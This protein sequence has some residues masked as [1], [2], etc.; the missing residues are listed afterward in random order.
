MPRLM[1]ARRLEGLDG[2]R[3]IAALCV[4]AYHAAGFI[5]PGIAG[6]A[7]LAVD[8]FFLLSGFVMA[9]TYDARL[10]SG[11]A[12]AD[13][14]IARVRRLWPMMALGGVI[15]MPVA[16]LHYGADFGYVAVSGLLLVPVLFG[17][18]AF[19]LNIPC[20][21][22]F[23]EL[24]ANMFHGAVLR[25]VSVR[26][27]G[28][29]IAVFAVLMVLVAARF[30]AD[31]GSAPAHFWWALVRVGLPYC[32]GVLL[33]RLWGDRPPLAVPPWIAFAAMP[34]VFAAVSAWSAWTGRGSTWAL[35]IGLVAAL[36]PLLLMGG[37]AFRG[38]SVVARLGGAISF[39]LYAVHMPLMQLA[40]RLDIAVGWAV[41]ASLVLAL[42]LAGQ[43]R[44][45]LR[46]PAP[47][48]AA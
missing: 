32:S 25:R 47:T 40:E 26:A 11:L 19:P 14:M 1:A 15:G 3:G 42:L 16:W 43:L 24:V 8:F 10:V 5:R 37:M 30:G 44:L 48:P 36:W 29:L 38:S 6:N 33:W 34:I 45:P 17:T 2:L 28:G 20:W 46:A 35:D 18:A 7:Y 9:R 22:I 39:P 13:F 21:S 12:A 23:F 4:L 31:V 27:L 41:A